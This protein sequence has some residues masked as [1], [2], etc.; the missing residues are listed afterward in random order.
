M[1]SHEHLLLL[2]SYNPH[3]YFHALCSLLL[4][5]AEAKKERSEL[6][7]GEKLEEA[8]KI[9]G[10]GTDAFKAG[11]YVAAHMFYIEAAGWVD[12]SMDFEADDGKKSE[13][14]SEGA[15]GVEK[16][17][18]SPAPRASDGIK[19]QRMYQLHSQLHSQLQS[20][21]HSQLHS[22]TSL[23]IRSS[24]DWA[25]FPQTTVHLMF[26]RSTSKAWHPV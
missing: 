13:K 16:P 5:W 6:S 10:R 17:A 4:S 7:A 18:F 26:L 20:R 23:H 1:S 14:K 22:C 21:L 2:M 8:A 24:V 12:Q 11:E 3:F 15:N 19:L 25:S 9:K